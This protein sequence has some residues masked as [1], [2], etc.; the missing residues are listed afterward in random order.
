MIPKNSRKF[1]SR[2]SKP[3]IDDRKKV[4]V[5][6]MYE[7]E[8]AGMKE[9]LE[10]IFKD[11]HRHPELGFCEQRTAAF[12]ADYLTKCGLEVRTGVAMTG[13]IATLDS[14]KSGKTLMIRADM[15]CLAVLER[16]ECEYRSEE[17]GKM[18]ACGHDSH[19]TMLLG[20]AAILA[21]HKEAFNGKIKFVFQPAEEG[22]PP[23]MVDAVKEAGY[24]G[25][26]G[27]GFMVQEGVL[28]EVD[29]CV[30]MHVQPTLP[31]GTVSISRKNACASSD[32]FKIQLLGK[33]GHGAQPQMAVDPVPAAS[34]LISAIHMLPTREVDPVETCVISI[35]KLETTGS[36]WNVVADR[37]CI[38]G[39]Y[40]T[41]NE[42]VRATLTK[43]IEELANTIGKANRCSVDYEHIV[44][45]KPCI[46]DPVMA[47]KIVASCKELL[48]EEHVIDTEMPAMS[49]EDCGEYLSRI[50]GVFFWLGVGKEEGS[51]PLHNP[52]FNLDTEALLTGVR[53][54]VNNAVHLLNEK[55]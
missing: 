54:H 17:E 35:G 46:N 15:D 40:R 9:E 11:L 23:C 21:K 13:V 26:G 16:A 44:G 29:F 48:G 36:V 52:Y 49:S 51:A 20:A 7:N 42:D 6:S 53:V 10:A 39:G 24:Q 1:S 22:T 34:E 55:C 5:Q 8:I 19:V 45:Y 30:I 2:L 41:F 27:A 38:E 28:E 37:V 32:I 4:G 50:P 12:I 3:A 47:Q 25:E 43:R 14:G 31:T 18:H 33:G